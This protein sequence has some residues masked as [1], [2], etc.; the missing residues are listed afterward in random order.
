MVEGGGKNSKD[1]PSI[2]CTECKG[3]LFEIEKKDAER[4]K[5]YSEKWYGKI[6]CRDCQFKHKKFVAK[7]EG[8]A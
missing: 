2:I 8:S 4:V 7:Q 5:S 1:V 6:L 3:N